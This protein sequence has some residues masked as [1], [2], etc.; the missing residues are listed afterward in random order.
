MILSTLGLTVKYDN[1][2]IINDI[3]IEL[4]QG[5][6]L[7]ILGKNGS[8]KSTLCLAIAGLLSS[9]AEMFGKVKILGKD[10]YQLSRA[11][12][13]D[14]I[15][16]VFQ[17][18]DTQLF[19]PTVEDELAFAPENLCLSRAEIEARI[20]YA[21]ELCNI[22]HLRERHTNTLSGGE[23]QLVALASVLT[24]R[25]RILI[26]DELTASIDEDRRPQIYDILRKHATLGAVILVTHDKEET[27]VCTR[28]ITLMGTRE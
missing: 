19:S 13:S 28:T 5:E 17:N 18:P 3:N 27:A 25:P 24:M 4:N 26:A 8:G 6:I 14:Y 2:T 23:K 7:G 9:D 11:E 1:K 20:K 12:K 10:F 21:L 15:G 22:S 16:I